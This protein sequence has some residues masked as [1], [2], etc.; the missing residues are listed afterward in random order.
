MHIMSSSECQF[1]DFASFNPTTDVVYGKPKVNQRGM[2][3]VAIN[4]KHSGRALHL[5]APLMLTWGVNVRNNEDGRESYDFSLQF[6]NADYSNAKADAF[7][8]ALGALEK[9]LFADA[10]ANSKDWFNK[11]KLSADQIEVLYNQM[12]YRPKDPETGEPR[13]GAAPSLRVKLDCWDGE[14]KQDIYDPSHNKLYPDSETSVTPVDLITKGSQV[15]CILRC[16]GMY[17]VNGKFGVTWRLVQAIVKPKA[18]LRG[19]C[20]IVLD[21]DEKRALEAQSDGEDETTKDSD[22]DDD[23]SVQIGSPKPAPPSEPAPPS[24]PVKPKRRVVR[25]A[26]KAADG[27]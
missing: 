13:Q 24:S 27:V 2:K 5:S 21:E 9:K 4:S 22:D 23:S 19:K 3:S 18:S 20:H 17:F 8:A 16:G 6:P 15:A 11:S 12:L 10:V 7:L 26:R 14:F 25:K 1:I